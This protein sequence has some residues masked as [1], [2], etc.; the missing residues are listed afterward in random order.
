MNEEKMKTKPLE[1]KIFSYK[2]DDAFRYAVYEIDPM[3]TSLEQF[4]LKREYDS[5]PALKVLREIAK[6]YK[7]FSPNDW[8]YSREISPKYRFVS[9]EMKRK[10]PYEMNQRRSFACYDAYNGP[11]E[12]TKRGRTLDDIMC[13]IVLKTISKKEY[14]AVVNKTQQTVR[15]YLERIRECEEDFADT[16][17]DILRIK[18]SRHKEKSLFLA[19]LHRFFA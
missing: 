3:F 7:D 6:Y 11:P 2:P 1:I 10:Y 4:P 12:A 18:S 14:D 8:L 16:M 13:K 9:I 19:S 15:W 17:V 5:D